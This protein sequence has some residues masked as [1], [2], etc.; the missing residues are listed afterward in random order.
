MQIKHGAGWGF[1]SERRGGCLEVRSA[2][3]QTDGKEAKP[4]R[5]DEAR[6]IIEEYAADPRDIIRK[7]RRKMN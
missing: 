3:K 2:L 4:W 5:S 7:L 1:L 6:W